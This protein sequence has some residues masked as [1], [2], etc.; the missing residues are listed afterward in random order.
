MVDRSFRDI[1]DGSRFYHVP[2]SEALDRLVFGDTSRAVRATD[3]AGVAATVL[4][5]TVIP[6]LLSLQDKGTSE[7]NSHL[8]V[9]VNCVIRPSKIASNLLLRYSG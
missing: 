5:T 4:V 3:K 1:T 9:E 7:T 6:P 8:P 2:D